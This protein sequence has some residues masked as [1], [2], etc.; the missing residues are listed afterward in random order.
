VFNGVP[1]R[2]STRYYGYGS[3]SGATLAPDAVI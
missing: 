2:R 1:V 3:G